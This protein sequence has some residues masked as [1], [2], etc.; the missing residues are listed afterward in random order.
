MLRVH[1]LRDLLRIDDAMPAGLIELMQTQQLTD[2]TRADLYLALELADTDAAQAALTSVIVDPAAALSDGMRAVVA[3]AGVAR[4]TPAAVATLWNAALNARPTE[5]AS[6]A[7]LA[8]GSVGNS[9]RENGDPGYTSLRTQLLASAVGGGTDA[10][11]ANYV[12]AVGN[13][14][15]ATLA[16]NVVALLGDPAPEVRRAAALSLGRLDPDSAA[17]DLVEQFE[18]ERDNR[19]RG[20]IAESLVSWTEPTPEAVAMISDGVRTELDENTRFNMARFL[21]VNLADFPDNRRVLEDLLRVEQSR[22]IRQNVA[23]ALAA[24][25]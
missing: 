11:R 10:Q 15:D 6:T 16:P 23:E 8:L 17:R 3:L 5:L 21:A 13:T 20:A 4:P 1:R 2:R 14:R 9:M 12:H 22:R 25:R 19:V 18:R 7:T 24:A